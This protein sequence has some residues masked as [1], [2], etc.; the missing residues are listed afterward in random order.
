MEKYSNTGG[1]NYPG[2]VIYFEGVKTDVPELTA[3]STGLTGGKPGATTPPTAKI[4]TV[5]QGGTGTLIFEPINHEFLRTPAELPSVLV[6]VNGITS[7]CKGDCSY[8]TNVVGLPTLTTATLA[9]NIVTLAL[10]VNTAVTDISVTVG[11]QPCTYTEGTYTAYK[12][13]LPKHTNGDP[14]LEVGDYTPRVYIKGKGY[15]KI[16]GTFVK[17]TVALTITSL[18][19]S[20]GN[21]NGGVLV[22]MVGKGFPTDKSKTFTLQQCT[23]N[24]DIVSV[25]NTEIQFYSAPCADASAPTKLTYLTKEATSTFT[26]SGTSTLSFSDIVPATFSPVHQGFL[27]VTGAGF[28]T[29][30]NLI[31]AWLSQANVKK[32]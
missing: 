28:G 31:K 11:G 30:K 26:Y 24:V 8:Q 14:I 6:K 10:D 13:A 2:F 27:T 12:C 25:S 20:T 32:Y 9:T 3:I 4:T 5:R 18:T 17:I 29:D 21:P 1:S 19:P 15:A 7:Q 16:P 22:K 23:K